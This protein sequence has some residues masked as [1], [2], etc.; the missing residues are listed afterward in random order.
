MLYLPWR[1]G[2]A[3]HG[4]SDL[5]RPGY[6]GPAGVAPVPGLPGYSVSQLV[7]PYE[8]LLPE[9]ID[10]SLTYNPGT[11]PI[12]DIAG[13]DALVISLG[14]WG[15]HSDTGG[16][17]W[18][19][20]QWGRTDHHDGLAA[21]VAAALD[22]VEA[23]ATAGA[24]GILI[25]GQPPFLP[26]ETDFSNDGLW[27]SHIDGYEG[28]HQYL[29]D[30]IRQWLDN[31][32]HADMF[33][34]IVP[35][36]RLLARIYDDVQA[37]GIVP[38]GVTDHRYFR[39]GYDTTGGAS[40][41]Q[42]MLSEPGIWAMQALF[43][44]VAYN[45]LSSPLPSPLPM[46][47]YVDAAMAAYL[48]G[49]ATEIADD[50]AYAGRGGSDRSPVGL[51]ASTGATP[52]EIFAAARIVQMDAVSD[53]KW[54]DSARTTPAVDG[55]PVAAI[56]DS[57][58]VTDPARVPI[59][60]GDVIHFAGD[61]MRA[62]VSP[63][64]TPAYQAMLVDL[65]Y[66]SGDHRIIEMD[67]SEVWINSGGQWA[68][69]SGGANPQ[70]SFGGG[71][72]GDRALIEVI[73]SGGQKTIRLT[74]LARL[75]G[76]DLVRQSTWTSAPIPAAVNWAQLSSTAYG[77]DHQSWINWVLVADQV[78]TY[79]QRILLYDWIAARVGQEVW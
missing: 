25:Y 37:G 54:A 55:G 40:T 5:F 60:D 72:D 27:R 1:D 12:A 13:Y 24:K 34:R 30:A 45:H 46:T 29:A 38:G 28:A 8:R 64:M 14:D 57:W 51:V 74:N 15:W 77:E 53:A 21:N 75:S 22:L 4:M 6:S 7:A 61:P 2:V 69:A 73:W 71:V 16:H 9:M 58:A 11:D 52:A 63:A 26:S 23:A 62:N 50:Y 36:H 70:A 18:Q 10:G 78:P 79:D 56:G 47:T 35:A 66:M 49:I 48:A 32:G 39:S 65:R 59:L 41:H 67:G 42:Y 20:D 33:C 19:P 31:N 43:A 68:Q 76:E 3:D 17:L 44:L